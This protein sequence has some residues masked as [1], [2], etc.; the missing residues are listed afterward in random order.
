MGLDDLAGFERAILAFTVALPVLALLLAWS[1]TAAAGP[2][3]WLL[4]AVIAGVAFTVHVQLGV[5]S[6]TALARGASLLGLALC[7]AVGVRL[8]VV[9][10]ELVARWPLASSRWARGVAL[11]A[12]W[13]VLTLTVWLAGGS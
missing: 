6:G 4:A 5:Q 13:S 2:L 9:T 11:A 10:D 1:R 3:R 8:V 12:A 7:I